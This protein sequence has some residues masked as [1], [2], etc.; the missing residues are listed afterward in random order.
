M[1]VIVQFALGKPKTLNFVAKLLDFSLLLVDLSIGFVKSCLGPLDVSNHVGLRLV[2][3]IQE[4]LV[5]LNRCFLVI[6]LLLE[7]VDLL[8][9]AFCL[10]L[11]LLESV[12]KEETLLDSPLC[13]GWGCSDGLN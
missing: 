9:H 12:G 5:E 13:S 8:H 11:L 2:G 3:S 1:Q 4:S 6:D 10:F 7:V